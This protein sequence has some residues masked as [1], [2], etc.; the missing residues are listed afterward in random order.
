M[1]GASA[2]SATEAITTKKKRK[3]RMGGGLR[4]TGVEKGQRLVEVPGLG[5]AVANSRHFKIEHALES[6]FE[7][8]AVIR[9]PRIRP[10]EI[11]LPG[12]EDIP[13]LGPGDREH[14]VIRDV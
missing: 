4:F 8:T 6:F 14:V 13:A 10:I 1:S 5:Q 12:H 3:K 2:P 7:K 11:L 9:R